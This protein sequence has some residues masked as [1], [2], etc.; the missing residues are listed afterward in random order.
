[1]VLSLMT[2][3]Q[4]LLIETSMSNPGTAIFTKLTRGSDRETSKHLVTRLQYM[5]SQSALKTDNDNNA[6]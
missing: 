1:M 5:L 6:M 4:S 3:Y 2:Q